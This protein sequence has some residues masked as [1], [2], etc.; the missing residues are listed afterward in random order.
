MQVYGTMCLTPAGGV[1]A[2]GTP[3][4]IDTA[5]ARRRRLDVRRRQGAADGRRPV[6]RGDR[7]DP[8]NLAPTQ[9]AT[10]NG[11]PAAVL[12]LGGLSHLPLHA[13]P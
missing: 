10:C 9:L 2:A 5:P 3:V 7:R 6:P 11:Q 1:I 4:V 12:D 8:N 13:E